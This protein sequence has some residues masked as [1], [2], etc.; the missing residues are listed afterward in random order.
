MSVGVF[1]EHPMLADLRRQ[2][3]EISI[4]N[5]QLKT[6]NTELIETRDKLKKKKNRWGIAAM[7]TG[8]TAITTGTGAFLSNKAKSK[9]KKSIDSSQDD[10]V[11]ESK[12]RTNLISEIQNLQEIAESDEILKKESTSVLKAKFNKLLVEQKE[13]TDAENLKKQKKADEEALKE[14]IKEWETR[15]NEKY[16]EVNDFYKTNNTKLSAKASPAI[17][18]KN[19]YQNKTNF[20]EKM[21]EYTDLLKEYKEII[22]NPTD[23]DYD[24]ELKEDEI[25]PGVTEE[26]M[27]KYFETNQINACDEKD[28]L[29][30][31]TFPLSMNSEQLQENFKYKIAYFVKNCP[32]ITF[33]QMNG[34]IEKNKG[35]KTGKYI[36]Q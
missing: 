18:V 26:Q 20:D 11:R 34:N 24:V 19:D 31:I 27:N 1:A 12:K 7:L 28:Q 35:T 4:I 21:N 9:I 23:E 14:Q 29:T 30:K 33:L 3:S 2:K 5:Q 6:K 10:V 13:K 32:E 17:V 16:N 25:I 15:L 22:K 8:A 36:K